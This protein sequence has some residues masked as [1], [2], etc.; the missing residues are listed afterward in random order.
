VNLVGFIIRIYYDAWSPERL[1]L[2]LLKFF[3]LEVIGLH[4]EDKSHTKCDL[5]YDSS[6]R[7]TGRREQCNFE[8]KVFC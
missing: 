6:R 7:E 1:M 4:T 3:R 5:E 8:M 2:G